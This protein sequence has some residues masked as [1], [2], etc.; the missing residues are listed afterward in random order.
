MAAAVIANVFPGP[1]D[2][3]EQGVWSLQN[4]PDRR[5]LMRLQRHGGTRAGKHEV[6]AIKG[7]EPE[8]VELV[9]VNPAKPF[10]ALVILPDPRLEAFFEFV[11]LLARGLSG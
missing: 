5:L 4:P 11:L 3:R 7:A 1:Y 8:V 9:V 10:P 6:V 2:V